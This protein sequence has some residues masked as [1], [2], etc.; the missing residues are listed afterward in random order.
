MQPS[1]WLDLF[2]F[3]TWTEFL[4]AGGTVSGFRENR[5]KTL[6][7][8]RPGDIFLCYLTGVSR[9]IGLLEVTGP[10][11]KDTTPI[12]QRADFPARI[13]VRVLARLEPLHGVP[14]TEMRELSVFDD[15]KNPKAWT[16]RFR[17]SPYKWSEADGA[18]VVAAV[19]AAEAAPIERPFE[20]S[21]LRK[22][23]P[24]LGSRSALLAGQRAQFTWALNQYER[25]QTSDEK[26][27]YARQVPGD[28]ACQGLHDRR[29][30]SE[31][32]LP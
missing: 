19:R 10:A 4:A 18:A 32:A 28:G 11:F 5:W 21:K 23:P 15:L 27:S 3:E 25:A 29:D 20:S 12:W 9:W 16:G 2:T 1:Y 6:Q 22:V 13:P 24:L 31:Q 7:T 14:V 30:Q 26:A 8:I 17:G